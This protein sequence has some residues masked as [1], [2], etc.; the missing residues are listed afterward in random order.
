ME[1]DGNLAYWVR[2]NVTKGCSRAVDAE[3]RLRI[4]V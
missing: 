1:V 2:R 4:E 3:C